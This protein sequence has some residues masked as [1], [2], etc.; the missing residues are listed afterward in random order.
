MHEQK[1]Y[2]VTYIFLLLLLVF[3]STKPSIQF[4]FS[5]LLFYFFFVC[6]FHKQQQQLR[7]DHTHALVY[8][9]ILYIVF[10][11]FGSTIPI[12]HCKK[13]E[14]RNVVA[15][16]AFLKDMK[17]SHRIKDIRM[18][19]RRNIFCK[20][21]WNKTHIFTKWIGTTKKWY[22][23]EWMECIWHSKLK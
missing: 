19:W 8:R 22:P 4:N 23:I 5:L 13:I 6:Y 9:D 16:R 1:H 18:K 21:K 17:I 2:K 7:T 12:H 11:G 15:D 20:W 3:V 10:V 14:Y